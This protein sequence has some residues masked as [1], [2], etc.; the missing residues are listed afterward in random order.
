M[1]RCHVKMNNRYRNN[2]IGTILRGYISDLE[3]TCYVLYDI[4]FPLTYCR[5]YEYFMSILIRRSKFLFNL[6]VNLRDTL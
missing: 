6:I 4:M 3:L 1:Y 2:Y 5:F